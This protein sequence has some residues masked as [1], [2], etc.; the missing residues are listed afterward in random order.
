MR[1]LN[2]RPAGAKENIVSSIEHG[3]DVLPIAPMQ[4]RKKMTRPDL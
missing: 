1:S 3:K 4:S 2:I